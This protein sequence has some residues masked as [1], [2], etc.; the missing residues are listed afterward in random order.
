MI[1][2]L[3][4]NG[5]GKMMCITEKGRQFLRGNITIVETPSAEVRELLTLK[6]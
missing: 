2:K 4:P 3:V 6:R 1:E 5:Y